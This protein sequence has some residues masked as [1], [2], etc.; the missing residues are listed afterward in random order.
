MCPADADVFRRIVTC[1]K[2]LT[3]Y[4]FVLLGLAVKMR[5]LNGAL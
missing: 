1:W 2:L 4:Q 5:T 3:F